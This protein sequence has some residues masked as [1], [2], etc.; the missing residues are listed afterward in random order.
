MKEM[1]VNKRVCFFSFQAYEF[2]SN[3]LPFPT[4]I[5]DAINKFMPQ[6]A[7]KRNEKLQE[8]MRVILIYQI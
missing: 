7:V 4:G 6:L 8:T 2:Q 3:T 1:L 5:I